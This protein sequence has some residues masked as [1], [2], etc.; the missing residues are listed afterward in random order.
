MTLSLYLTVAGHSP[1]RHTTYESAQYCSLLLRTTENY[2]STSLY[3]KVLLQYFSVL[4]SPTPVVL[5]TTKSYSS[6]TL[7]SK[8]YARSTPVLLRTT[9]Y[10]YTWASPNTAPAT[11]SD[12]WAS[13][14]TAPATKSDTRTSP[15]TAPDTKSDTWTSPSTAPATK[16]DTWT[17][18]ST[19]PATKKTS[20][21]W[22]VSHMKRYLQ[23]AEQQKSSWNVTKYCACHQK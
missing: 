12:T 5:R 6:T 21:D 16:S 14:T 18:P 23:G 7:Y 17:S 2:S 13:P 15:S 9:L 19:A 22:S 10:C 11:K 20:H 3:Y 4:Q 1:Q 8:Y